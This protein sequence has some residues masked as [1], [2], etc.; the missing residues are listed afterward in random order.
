SDDTVFCVMEARPCTLCQERNRRRCQRAPP[1]PATLP[2]PHVL[3]GTRTHP[4]GR[5]RISFAVPGLR[6]TAS[7]IARQEAANSTESTTG[8]AA[9]APGELRSKTGRRPKGPPPLVVLKGPV[10]D[11]CLKTGRKPRPAPPPTQDSLET[12][13]R[14]VR[15][16]YDANPDAVDSADPD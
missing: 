4:K 11:R 9:I 10:P 8:P 5:K 3:M 6:P 7:L 13:L 14:M 16:S 12:P 15:E 1:A 2:M